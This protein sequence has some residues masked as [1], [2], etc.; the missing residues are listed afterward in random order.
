MRSGGR[1]VWKSI[2]EICKTS[3]SL[4][5]MNLKIKNTGELTSNAD[6]MLSILYDHHACLATTNEK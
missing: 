6:E 5:I 1:G 2:N 4:D 3:G